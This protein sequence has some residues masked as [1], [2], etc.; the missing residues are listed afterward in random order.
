MS[1]RQRRVGR[2][3]GVGGT[4]RV[5]FVL[6][7]SRC[8]RERIR[9]RTPVTEAALDVPGVRRAQQGGVP[10]SREAMMIRM[11][12]VQYVRRRLRE[13]CQLTCQELRG[14]ERQRGAR[15]AVA[16]RPVVSDLLGLLRLQI[17]PGP[18]HSFLLSRHVRNPLNAPRSAYALYHTL[19]RYPPTKHVLSPSA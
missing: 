10:C 19:T 11:Q 8:A 9:Q 2:R 14:G 7:R 12:S 1:R 5:I 4:R 15:D 6:R 17:D 16:R 13:S 18:T 3:A